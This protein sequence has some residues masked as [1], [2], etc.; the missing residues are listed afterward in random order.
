M[1]NIHYWK[2]TRHQQPEKQQGCISSWENVGL[3][4]L[5]L[6]D[7]KYNNNKSVVLDLNWN[8]VGLHALMDEIC[9]T[10]AYAQ[11]Q[12]ILSYRFKIWT[13]C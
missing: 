3:A 12:K 8:V 1:R 4:T 11:N 10:Y 2:S 7:L 9:F 6:L 5:L 13:K